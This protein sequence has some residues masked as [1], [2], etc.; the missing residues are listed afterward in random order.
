MTSPSVSR[1]RSGGSPRRHVNRLRIYEFTNLRIITDIPSRLRDTAMPRGTVVSAGP[2]VSA[3]MAGPPVKA[4]TT[5]GI[6]PREQVPNTGALGASRR[7]A[8]PAGQLSHTVGR[9]GKGDRPGRPRAG[10][11]VRARAADGG[12]TSAATHQPADN[13]RCAATA[14]ARSVDQTPPSAE[15][16]HECGSRRTLPG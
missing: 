5:P 6:C 3:R 9:D 12:L 16:G 2:M 1:P 11:D 10:P 13:A 14:R 4:A 15:C 8:W 7:I